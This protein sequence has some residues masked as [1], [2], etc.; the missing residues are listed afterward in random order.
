MRISDDRYS[1][2]RLRYDLA[3]RFLGHQART[4]T[5]RAWTGLTHDRIRKLYRTYPAG[6]IVRRHR[7]KSPQRIGYF[8][9]S[10]RRKFETGVLASLLSIFEVLPTKSAVDGA[11]VMPS[12]ARGEL[13]CDAFEAYRVM[14]PTAKITF[15][16]AA[17]LAEALAQGDEL[18]LA[19][20]GD[21]TC[22][23]VVDRLSLLKPCCAPCKVP[24]RESPAAGAEEPVP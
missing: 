16:H 20:C 5:I 15:E 6:G 18:R 1:R 3:I 9:R 4:H 13:L 7:G 11:R 19:S 14:L 24:A 12:V 23:V 2:D 10:H 17:F 21:C 8:M 22:L